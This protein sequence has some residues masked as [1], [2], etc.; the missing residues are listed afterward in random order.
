MQVELIS[1]TNDPLFTCEQAACECYD[2]VPDKEHPSRI[3]GSCIKSGHQSVSEHANFTFRVTGISRACLAQLTRHRLAAFSVRS[4]RY[5][6]E[7]E[8]GYVTP[9]SIEQNPNARETYHALMQTIKNV[10][11]YY[12]Q[13]LGIANEDARFVLP[14]ACETTLTMTVNLRELIHI[15]HERLCSRAQW[16][17]RWLVSKMADL[18][19]EKFPETEQWLVPKCEKD[20]AH[21]FCTERQ[22]CGRHKK[23]SEGYRDE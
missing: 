15:C 6:G 2:S 12:T 16:E 17:I 11:N 22:C 10:Y 14:N 20:P 1:Y 7:G 18:V 21:P 9:P 13:D 5:C 19:A 23:L 3:L 8:F 4:Q